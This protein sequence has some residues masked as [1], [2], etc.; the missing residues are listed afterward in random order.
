[1]GDFAD[2]QIARSGQDRK[3]RKLRQHRL[4]HG[5]EDFVFPLFERVD[6]LASEHLHERPAQGGGKG[7]GVGGVCAVTVMDHG[8]VADVL[9]EASVDGFHECR[10]VEAVYIIR[11]D[12][13]FLFGLVQ[14]G[15]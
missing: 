15:C 10:R 1:M 9:R 6:A 11:G 3:V 7:Y 14:I 4:G 8:E 12:G 2:I 5:G 13:G